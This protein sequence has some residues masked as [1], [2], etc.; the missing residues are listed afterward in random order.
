MCGLGE[1]DVGVAVIQTAFDYELIEFLHVAHMS[2][3]GWISCGVQ[4]A[5][6]AGITHSSCLNHWPLKMNKGGV[7]F[8]VVYI[9]ASIITIS[10]GFERLTPVVFCPLSAMTV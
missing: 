10:F 7:F 2:H 1:K 3:E 6:R 9:V 8:P 4:Q 5:D